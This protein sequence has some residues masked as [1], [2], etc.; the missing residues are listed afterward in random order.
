MFSDSKRHTYEL[1]IVRGNYEKAIGDESSWSVPWHRGK[2][3]KSEAMYLHI[4]YFILYAFLY[5]YIVGS[6]EH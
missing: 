6:A 2:P 4:F 5:V 3:S 1:V